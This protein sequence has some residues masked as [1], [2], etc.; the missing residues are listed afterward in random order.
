MKRC[1]WRGRHH[2][3]HETQCRLLKRE[4]VSGRR[5]E[6]K[7]MLPAANICAYSCELL[8]SCNP[9]DG[10]KDHLIYMWTTY[11]ELCTEGSPCQLRTSRLH[12]FL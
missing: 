7:H 5:P 3:Q 6:S 8:Q 11:R 10:T 4:E 12:L 9:C 2:Y 1:V